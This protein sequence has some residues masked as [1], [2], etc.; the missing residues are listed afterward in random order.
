MITVKALDHFVLRVREL[1]RSLG[2][3]QDVLGL[4][5]EFLD[6]YRAGARPFVSVRI[7]E[8]ILD[9]VP[10]STYDA[11]A[12]RNAGG[13]LHFCV[14]IEAGRLP[15]IIAWLKERGVNVLEEQPVP[16]MG[17]TGMGLSIY[18]TDPDGY[19]VELKEH[20]A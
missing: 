5:I 19:V 15:G 7:G 18:I 14:S 8:Q 16:R 3:Y 13:F 20:G 12:S 6:E 1:E 2:F 10:D 17:A 9:L 4:P 11:D